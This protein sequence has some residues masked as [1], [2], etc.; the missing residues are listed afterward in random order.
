M[1]LYLS[2]A[3]HPDRGVAVNALT[4]DDPYFQ[5]CWA[6]LLRPWTAHVV[7]VTARLTRSQAVQLP[8]ERLSYELN[9]EP[10]KFWVRATT[11][12]QSLQDMARQ[13]FGEVRWLSHVQADVRVYRQV[14]L[15]PE[16]EL[17]RLT[18]PELCAHASAVDD[19]NKRRATAGFPLVVHS[20]RVSERLRRADP[21][22]RP[23]RPSPAAVAIARL[24]RLG[25]AP[26]S[27]RGLSL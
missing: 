22:L 13:G 14:P 7:E 8:L 10:A 12:T 21:T 20:P 2:Q 25:S 4:H 5:A 16:V 6:P 19:A 23:S 18:D 1:E 24:D 11:V 3:D 9:P 26:P 15:I 17:A 27:Q